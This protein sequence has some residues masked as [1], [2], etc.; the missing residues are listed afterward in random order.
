MPR[1]ARAETYV[2]DPPKNVPIRYIRFKTFYLTFCKT[3]KE[4]TYNQCLLTNFTKFH[5]L[6]YSYKRYNKVILNSPKVYYYYL[7]VHFNK[8]VYLKIHM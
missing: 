6:F 7:D 8:D 4:Y 3:N 1:L 5:H 2:C